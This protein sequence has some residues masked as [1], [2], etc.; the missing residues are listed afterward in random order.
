MDF[1]FQSTDFGALVFGREVL[2]KN[3]NAV[4]KLWV[5]TPPIPPS[6]EGRDIACESDFWET[7]LQKILSGLTHFGRI[8]IFYDRKNIAAKAFF[9]KDRF[10]TCPYKCK[11][12]DKRAEKMPQFHTFET[13]ALHHLANEGLADTVE[14]RRLARK[15]LRH[16]KNAH[17]D[18]IFFTEAIFGEE[19]TRKILQHI[20]GTQMRVMVPND[21]I[22][23]L[24]QVQDDNKKNQKR[25][26]KI[27]TGD[28]VEFTRKRA[29]EIL[30]TKLR[31]SNVRSEA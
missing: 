14:F 20:A 13:Q 4:L 21:F 11:E 3:P 19:K 28:D 24:K 29:E 9:C 2:K 26:I 25:S 30:R 1:K 22:E 16:A 7:G 15:F 8:G 17:C 18:T 10:E 12:K 6:K 23:I 5:G 31:A 27:H